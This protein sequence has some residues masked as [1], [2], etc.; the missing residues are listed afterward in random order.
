MSTKMEQLLKEQYGGVSTEMEGLQTNLRTN[1]A[2]QDYTQYPHCSDVVG[3]CF[4]GA[5]F[6]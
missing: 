3:Q 4:L 6:T 1:I 5:A 2:Q